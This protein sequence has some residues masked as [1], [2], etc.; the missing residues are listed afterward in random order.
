MQTIELHRILCPVDFSDF[1]RRAL[2]HAGALAR[3]Y[4][5]SITILHVGASVPVAAYSIG[6]GVPSA[7]ALTEADRDRLLAALRRFADNSAVTHV[8][9]D[10]E[11]AEGPAA[12]EILKKA[13]A[14][15]A[16]LVVM[17]THG[18][19]GF[20]RL[21]LGSA[22]EKVL[23]KATCPVLTVPK[24][25]QDPVAV[26]P[27]LFKQIVC[28]IDY[29]DCSMRGLRYAASLAGET[30]AALTVVH[31][32]ELPPDLPREV[33]ETVTAGPRSLREYIAAAEEHE[34][35]RLADVL[36]NSVRDR[37]TTE[38]VVAAGAPYREI[39]RVA[40]ERKA[41]LLVIGV[42][43]RGPIRSAAVRLDSSAPG[44]SGVVSGTVGS[45]HVTATK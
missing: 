6:S 4:E 23:R 21:I 22:T 32:I 41:D 31:V 44:A 24:R 36:P 2:E 18:R 13:E 14:M 30:N 3:W 11:I 19:S 1:S 39:V 26:P 33:H 45:D 38:T 34:L 5:S 28:A 7:T 43:G 15:P 37:R 40:E 20:E 10:F 16:D 25:L 17:G 8:P 9:V 27:V 35:A 29:S 42:Q 12:A